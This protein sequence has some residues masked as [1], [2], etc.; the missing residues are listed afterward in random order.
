MKCAG[1][2]L[3][4]M[5][6]QIADQSRNESSDLDED[7]SN[8]LRAAIAELGLDVEVQQ[9]IV[10]VARTVAN[11]DRSEWIKPSHICEAINYRMLRRAQVSHRRLP[12]VLDA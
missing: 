2:A 3:A 5:Q 6:Q 4:D 11:L 9:R 8:L 12:S 10:A 1:M 7:C